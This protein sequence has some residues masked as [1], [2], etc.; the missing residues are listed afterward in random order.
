M[1]NRILADVTFFGFGV[2][3]ASLYF[4]ARVRALT[5][6]LRKGSNALNDAITREKTK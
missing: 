3:F 5:R 6:Q 1:L 4:L 2:I